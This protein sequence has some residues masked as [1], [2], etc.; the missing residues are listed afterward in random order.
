MASPRLRILLIL[1]MTFLL[2]GCQRLAVRPME[3]L[4]LAKPFFTPELAT[5]SSQLKEDQWKLNP[6]WRVETYWQS[7]QSINVH[8]WQYGTAENTK[9]LVQQLLE[10]PKTTISIAISSDPIEDGNRPAARP[11]EPIIS[12][13]SR[14]STLSGWNAAILWA[15]A[16]PEAAIKVAPVLEKIV[17]GE[18]HYS[19]PVPRT[20]PAANGQVPTITRGQSPSVP[21][22][23]SR[24]PVSRSNTPFS[25]QPE[26]PK[27]DVTWLKSVADSATGLGRA[28]IEHDLNMNMRAAAAEAWCHLL[29]HQTGNPVEHLAPV[30][31][32][33]ESGTLPSQ[34]Q[35]ELTRGVARWVSPKD[36]PGVSAALSPTEEV[37]G[38]EILEQAAMDAC[39]IHAWENFYNLNESKSASQRKPHQAE[40]W[41]E[42]I[43]H[44]RLSK[45]AELRAEYAYWMVYSNH[46]DALKHFQRQMADTNPN[47]RE[48]AF[49]GLGLLGSRDAIHLLETA[50]KSKNLIERQNAI[51]GLAMI[52]LNLV[53]PYLNDDE[54]RIR[55]SALKELLPTHDAAFL[56]PIRRQ[57]LNPRVEL[58]RTVVE[59]LSDW[60][61]ELALPVYLYGMQECPILTSRRLC[62]EVIQKR[63]NT[64]ET[65][66][67]EAV[68][69]AARRLMASQWAERHNIHQ[70]DA[71][72]AAVDAETTSIPKERELQQVELRNRLQLLSNQSTEDAGYQAE[73]TRLTE[74]EEQDALMLE[75][76]LP[77]QPAPLQQ[78]LRTQVLP[79]IH[80][81]YR[82]AEKLKSTQV[83]DRRSGAIQLQTLSERRTIPPDLFALIRDQMLKEQDQMVWRSV[84]AAYQRDRTPEAAELARIALHHSWPDIRLLGCQYIEFDPKPEYAE[85]L[86]PLM[87][88]KQ[89]RPLRLKA[90]QLVGNCR[91]PNLL[92]PRYPKAEQ[93]LPQEQG[94]LAL[95]Q[96]TE[97]ELRFAVISATSKLG[98][99]QTTQELI[100]MGQHPEANV[101]LRAIKAMGESGQTRFAKPLLQLGINEQQT[102]VQR[103][104]LNSLQ[105]L[106]TYGTTP[107]Q[108]IA[109][110][111]YEQQLKMWDEIWNPTPQTASRSSMNTGGSN[112]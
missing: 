15:Y 75:Q 30:G 108:D 100:F 49:R 87:H 46:P 74:L 62:L 21:S 97:P 83:E 5:Y 36:I 22:S 19:T 29:A 11:R 72:N 24:S 104:I 80:P 84:L 28:T 42:G 111:P 112:Y 45:N 106:T 109:R 58:H 4:A 2:T 60:P 90:I 7:G 88:E 31:R 55:Q 78:A 27:T 10:T 82:A 41:P 79:D 70:I 40:L 8:R 32:L 35:T 37:V 69:V 16:D 63:V 102:Q 56:I 81:L 44:L 110:Y 50:A 94:L 95:L 64:D 51:R 23:A 14:L 38:K 91:N 107:P 103:E 86:R 43:H 48:A 89:N 53:L 47:A 17:L 39:L 92:Q 34:I 1:L 18:C 12:Q 77:D 67:V 68:S 105:K 99:Q 98:Y 3:T 9:D 26:S 33:L 65:F 85:W 57:F 13:L 66:P 54:I 20:E 93:Q 101:R 52:N 73:L 76:M 59:G 25:V 96:E 6:E 61:D 71:L